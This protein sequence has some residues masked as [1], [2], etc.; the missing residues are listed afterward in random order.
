[1]FDKCFTP[2]PDGFLGCLASSSS[3]GFARKLAAGFICKRRRGG[4]IRPT[5]NP[6][7]ISF[8][9]CLLSPTALLSFLHSHSK[10]IAAPIRLTPRSSGTGRGSPA[11]GR[12]SSF[13]SSLSFGLDGIREGICRGCR[14]L[15]KRLKCYNSHRRVRALSVRPLSFWFCFSGQ[16]C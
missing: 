4:L 11:M 12:P 16:D 13:L 15:V 1:M 8:H 6:V 14:Q 10:T 7:F 3:F 9:F 5:P 2:F